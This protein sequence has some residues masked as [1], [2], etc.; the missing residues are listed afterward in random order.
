VEVLH[1]V[2][3]KI[4]N[5]ISADKKRAA[6]MF[7]AL[8]GIALILFSFGGGEGDAPDP[9][10][11]DTE[12]LEKSVAELLSSMDGVGRCVV[13]ISFSSGERREYKSGNLVYSEP[14]KVSGVSVVCEG[15]ANASAVASVKD[16][17]SALFGIGANRISVRK[18]K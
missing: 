6:A 13:K 9:H 2:I 15:G 4:G 5:F 7:F 10:T 17:I 16:A 3:R 8:F 14:A 18:M 12:E 1:G 11:F